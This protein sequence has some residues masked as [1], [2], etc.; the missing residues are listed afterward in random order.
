MNIAENDTTRVISHMG[1][2]H[3]PLGPPSRLVQFRKKVF[4][5]DCV[6][7]SKVARDGPGLTRE[8]RD[9]AYSL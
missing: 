8:R 3:E 4:N 7:Q 9:D 6:L 2:Y 1:L 5:F